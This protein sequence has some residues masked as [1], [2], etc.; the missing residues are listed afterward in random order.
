MLMKKK[1]AN[2]VANKRLKRAKR[3]MQKGLSDQFY[4]EMLTALWGYFSDK[5]SIPL[6]ELNRDNF[7]KELANYGMNEAD[8]DRIISILDE[9]EFARYAQSAAMAGI[10]MDKVFA[11]AV[12][13]IGTVENTKTKPVKK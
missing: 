7:S 5:L 12:E 8:I 3:F 2:K 13:T 1:G 10:S 9:C 4:E 6:S 11:E